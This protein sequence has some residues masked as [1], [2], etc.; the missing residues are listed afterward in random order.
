MKEAE[1]ARLAEVLLPAVLAAGHLQL[2]HRDAGVATERKADASPVTAAD[3]EAEAI[4]LQ[5]LSRAAPGVPVIAEEAVAQDG[6]PEVGET[7][8]L[9]D[10]LD[11]TREY[12][13]GLGEFT[14]NVGFIES[15]RPTFGLVYAPALAELY[16]TLGDGSAGA[17]T[18]AP[19]NGAARIEHCGLRPIRAREPVARALV[20]LDS[21]SHR[22]A[23]T[24]DLLA[25]LGVQEVKC[26][27]SS[28]K[29]CVIARGDADLYPRLGP[30]SEWDTAAGHAVLAA[31][32]GAVTTL[33]GEAL[34]YGKA[35]AR[36]LNPSFIAWGCKP[37]TAG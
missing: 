29:F 5:A 19:G 13:K 30:T 22:A 12:V 21:R 7:F 28:I 23:A 18:V 26:M 24:E 20:A 4:L 35:G 6:V 31:A 34:R 37:A 32:G 36:Y 15:G 10:P 27:G 1:H 9:V 33:D 16:V 11:G 2:R 25:R 8:F 17:A 14:I 3:R